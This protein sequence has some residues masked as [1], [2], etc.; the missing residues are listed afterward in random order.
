MS[1][2]QRAETRNRTKDDIRRV[3]HAIEKP[4]KWEKKW[5]VLK[6]TQLVVPKWIPAVETMAKTTAATSAPVIFDATNSSSQMNEDSNASFAAEESNQTQTMDPVDYGK[7]EGAGS[8]D[9]SNL[10]NESVG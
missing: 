1:R 4:R 2:S 6:D 10:K 9:F 3:M 8:T 5:V 7:T